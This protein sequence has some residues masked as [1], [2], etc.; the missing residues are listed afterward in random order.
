MI[1]SEKAAEKGGA[2]DM[3][4]ITTEEEMQAQVEKWDELI[5]E[6]AAGNEALQQRI[7]GMVEEAIER[8]IIWRVD[9]Y[10]IV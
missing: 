2:M 4:N 9:I 8:N 10:W 6:N 7:I 5:A 1:L 3:D